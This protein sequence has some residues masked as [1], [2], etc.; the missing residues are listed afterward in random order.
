MFKSTL[1]VLKVMWK[2]KEEQRETLSSQNLIINSIWNFVM[3]STN[4]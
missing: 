4:V 2:E 3:V 1:E